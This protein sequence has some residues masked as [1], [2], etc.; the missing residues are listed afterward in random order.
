MPV[1]E[2]L[3]DN[4]YAYDF[5][6]GRLGVSVLPFR[7]FALIWNDW[8]RDENNVDP[9]NI[10]KGDIGTYEFT[11]RNPWSP[12]NYTGELPKVA[13]FHDYFTSCLPSPQKGDAVELALQVVLYLCLQRHIT[14]LQVNM[15]LCTLWVII[16]QSVLT[17]RL[18]VVLVC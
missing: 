6:T 1:G 15:I 12:T 5:Q 11:N 2:R 8:F 7:A 9:C 13:K 17:K 16:W 10:I 18:P 4:D 14:L 3:D